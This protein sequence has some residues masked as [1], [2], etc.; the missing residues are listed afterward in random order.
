[1]VGYIARRFVGMIPTLMLLV[2]ATA[3]LVRLAPGNPVDLIL[4]ESLATPD[5]RAQLEDQLGLND[6]LLIHLIDYGGDVANGSLGHSLW[7]AENVRDKILERMPATVELALLAMVVA[8]LLGL[9]IGVLGAA[10][11]NRPEDLVSRTI[12][13]IFVSIP[14]FVLATAVVILPAVYWQW[15]PPL[16]YVRFSEDPLRNLEFFILPSLIL[17]TALSASI[18]RFTRTA[19]LEIYRADFMRTARSRGLSERA[20]L[21]RHGV[22]NALIPVITLVGTQI[23]TVLGGSVIIEQVFGIPGLGRL[24]LDA[25]HTRDYPV[26]QGIALSLGLIV[27]V[28]NLAVD[29]CY[30]IADPRIRLA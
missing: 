6:P 11:R 30:V 28:T 5:Q 19:M 1:M 29:V 8:V 16:K 22:R 20:V 18:A 21:W 23:A 12:V 27:L 10:R 2:V 25:I 15:T 9:P 17:G 24:L 13:L 7:N 3:A 14:N 26:V 4:Q